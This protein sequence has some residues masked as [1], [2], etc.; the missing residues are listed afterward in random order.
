MCH[1]V[2]SSETKWA[3]APRG[4]SSFHS[5]LVW[6]K[7]YH[8]IVYQSMIDEGR[9]G[10]ILCYYK[11]C[12][13][14][15]TM[16]CVFC[17]IPNSREVRVRRLGLGWADNSPGPPGQ[18]PLGRSDTRSNFTQREAE[19]PTSAQREAGSGQG[20]M[21]DIVRGLVWCQCD[22][23]CVS[24]LLRQQNV[25]VKCQFRRMTCWSRIISQ[26]KQYPHQLNLIRWS[27]GSSTPV[28][29]LGEP[30]STIS[31]ISQKGFSF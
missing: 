12:C 15:P 9:I 21:S 13:P 26:S 3:W 14:F 8:C 5:W 4:L 17:R 22:S 1:W 25:Q 10:D 18:W 20:G 24:R 2:L 6:R 23:W 11:S 7:L 28:L 30:K 27:I 29:G 31:V 19:Q 16:L